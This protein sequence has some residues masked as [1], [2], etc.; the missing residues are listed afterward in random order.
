MSVGG[1]SWGLQMG[2]E[3]IDLVMLVHER[4]RALL[5]NYRREC[6]WMPTVG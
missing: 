1:G 4:P 5:S 6:G 3:D 2:I